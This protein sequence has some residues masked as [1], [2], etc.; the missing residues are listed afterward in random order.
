MNYI[1][2]INHTYNQF[3]NLFEDDSFKEEE[4]KEAKYKFITEYFNYQFLT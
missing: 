4:R 3:I 1:D 2:K